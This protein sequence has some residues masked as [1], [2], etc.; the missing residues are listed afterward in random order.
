MANLRPRHR[1]HNATLPLFDYAERQRVR[2]VPAT[3]RR[4]A[5]AHGVP[6]ARAVQSF[7]VEADD[8]RA[9][10]VGLKG[11][12]AWA[13]AQLIEAGERGCTP[14]DQPGPRWSGYV[15]KLRRAG[16]GGVQLKTDHAWWVPVLPDLAAVL[17]AAP[18]AGR[19]IVLTAYG[20]PYSIKSLSMR[21]RDW[22]AKAGLPA[23]CVLHGLRK[24]LGK[25]LAEGGASTRQMMDV[26]GHTSVQH[27]E[28]YSRDARQRHMAAA[29]MR[30]IKGGKAA[31]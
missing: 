8:G 11:R 19:F 9:F 10:V 13:L 5:R 21:M 28:L 16:I 22:T 3:L 31:G 7:V 24:T 26:L 18:R 12:D 20:K 29:G 4:W 25:M 2:M 23:G 1:P 30:L 17:A 6:A 14:I 27:T 15:H